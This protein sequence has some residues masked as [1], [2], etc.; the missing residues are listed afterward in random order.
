[1]VEFLPG[2]K[3]DGAC[4]WIEKGTAPVIALSLR[5]DRLDN[6]WH[7][8][9]H[10]LDHIQHGEGKDEP[11]LDVL[12][13][14]CDEERMPAQE[15]RANRSAANLCV[16][17]K[18]LDHLIARSGRAPSRAEIVSFARSLNLHP[19]LVVGQLQHR[20]VVPY[21]FHRDLLEKVRAVVIESAVTDGFGTI[22]SV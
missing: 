12:E 13:I 8:L 7:T 20:G 3:L 11:I 14:E 21:S 5:L 17:R 10:E 6:F 4:F 22:R 9:F 16:D 15:L 19:A 1:M 18:M 2:A